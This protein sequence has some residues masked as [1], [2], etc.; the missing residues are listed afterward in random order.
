MKL[1]TSAKPP[2]QKDRG[3][4]CLLND[5]RFVGITLHIFMIRNLHH[6]HRHPHP[7]GSLLLFTRVF[8]RTQKK[9]CR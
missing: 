2:E 3:P 9:Q 6:H 4:V 1:P 5:G 7:H 8:L